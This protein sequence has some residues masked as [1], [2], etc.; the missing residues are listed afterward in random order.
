[1]IVTHDVNWNFHMMSFIPLKSSQ[2][3]D[4]KRLKSYLLHQLFNLHV[5]R[6]HATWT[7]SCE[8]GGEPQAKSQPNP[9]SGPAWYSEAVKKGAVIKRSTTGE[10]KLSEYEVKTPVCPMERGGC[11]S[12]WYIT[13]CKLVFIFLHYFSYMFSLTC[14]LKVV[15]F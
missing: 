13:P 12:D 5:F 6:E 3:H 4:I 1:M 9:R 2:K 11:L 14:F 8:R 7:Q 15:P 10:L